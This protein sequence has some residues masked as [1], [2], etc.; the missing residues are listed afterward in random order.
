MIISIL[1]QLI[2]TDHWLGKSWDMSDRDCG[3]KLTRFKMG[4]GYGFCGHSSTATS[5]G[6]KGWTVPGQDLPHG[7][8]QGSQKISPKVSQLLSGGA[9]CV[10][11]PISHEMVVLSSGRPQTRIWLSSYSIEDTKPCFTYQWG[12]CDLQGDHSNEHGD[13]LYHRY[14]FC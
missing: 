4:S 9:L 14:S 11:V 1:S 6:N 12:Q 2:T 7:A 13:K 3:G 10:W 8:G 5:K